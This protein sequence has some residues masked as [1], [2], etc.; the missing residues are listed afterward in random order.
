MV[1]SG[2]SKKKKDVIHVA[3]EYH[4]EITQILPIK[5]MYTNSKH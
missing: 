3:I 4:F 5:P 2:L 1:Q